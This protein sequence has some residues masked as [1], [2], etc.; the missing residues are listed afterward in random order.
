MGAREVDRSDVAKKAHGKSTG[1]TKLDVKTKIRK[2]KKKSVPGA[3][4]AK[5]KRKVN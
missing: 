3:K 2:P 1:D 5:A 4:K